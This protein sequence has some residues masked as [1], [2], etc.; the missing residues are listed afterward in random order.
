[1]NLSFLNA[2]ENFVHIIGSAAKARTEIDSIADQPAVIDMFPITVNAAATPP[3]GVM[4]LRRFMSLPY[5]GSL[6][7]NCCATRMM[8]SLR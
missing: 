8:S 3:S 1:M 2:V 6:L 5:F 7:S 4:S